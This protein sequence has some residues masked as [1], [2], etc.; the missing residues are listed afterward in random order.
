MTTFIKTYA[1]EISKHLGFL[2]TWPIN[3]D[4]KLGDVGILED[5]VFKRTDTLEN[6]GIGKP[7]ER[8]S[9]GE[10]NFEYTSKNGVAVEFDPNIE[11][12]IK[13]IGA[14]IE[15]KFNHWSSQG[16][17]GTTAPCSFFTKNIIGT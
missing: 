6:L 12:K 17:S 16:G 11:T 1:N 15:I 7:K 5:G 2:I 14:K 10:A 8:E 13:G 3:T 9:R 4:V